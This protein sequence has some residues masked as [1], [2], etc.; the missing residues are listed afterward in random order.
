LR[1]RDGR[2]LRILL[3][4]DPL[5]DGNTESTNTPAHKDY[6]S[7]PGALAWFF[8]KSRDGWKRKYQDLKATVKGYKN[9]IAD[10]T[11]SRE[12]WRKKAEQAGQRLSALEA[13]NAELRAQITASEEKKTDQGGGLL[14]LTPDEQGVPRG[15]QYAVGVVLRFVSLVLTCGA[16][17]RCAASV[18]RLVGP[19]TGPDETAPDRSTGRLWLQRL[20]LAAVQRPKILS[21]DWIWMIDHSIQ[22]GPCKTLVILGIRLCELPEGRP[23]GHQDLEPIA[24]VPMTHSTKQTVAACLEDAVAHTGVPRAIV[25]DHG[26]DLHG[27]VEIFRAAHPETSEVY[28]IT[29]K[30]ACLLKARLEG[31]VRWTTYASQLGQTKF[32]VQQT[33]LACLTPPSQ[34]SKARFMN[35]GVLVAWGCQTLALLDDPSRLSSLG[36]SGERVQ[37]KLGWLR[38]FREE[39]AEWS[40]YQEMID[41]ALDFVRC[42]GL[43][44]GAGFDLAAA[45]PAR[46]GGAGELREELIAF[47]RGESLKARLGE[48]LPGTTEVLESCF[49][50]LKALEDGQSKSGFTGLVLSLGAMVSKWTAESVGEALEQCRVRDVVAWC[51]KRLGRSVQSQ[52]RQ[53]YSGLAGATKPG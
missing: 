24:L 26:S 39:L 25:D 5:M 8:H 19:T 53:A 44:L 4:Q 14:R 51:R 29:H 40:A 42:R 12:Q 23:L 47:V 28:D 9:C 6:K 17:L 33:E 2:I 21:E 18:L 35:V 41:G 20:G 1:F 11:K 37:A 15:Q 52:R 30:A 49:G 22:I 38:E 43:Y 27:G 7:R 31:D 48:R 16:S 34:R 36:I 45:L 32:T 46:P 13:E 50:K 10:L 3:Q